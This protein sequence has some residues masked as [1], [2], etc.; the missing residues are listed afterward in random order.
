MTVARDLKHFLELKKKQGL[1]Q[2]KKA[3]KKKANA[4]AKLSD[5]APH[6][7]PRPET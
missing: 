5:Q 1:G 6:P 2:L 4:P 3:K 7:K